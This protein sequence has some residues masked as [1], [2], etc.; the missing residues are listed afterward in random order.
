MSTSVKIITESVICELSDAGITES[1]DR[2]TSESLG[3]LT[4]TD[5]GFSLSYDEQI[6]EEGSEPTSTEIIY[7][8]NAIL[9]KRRGAVKCDFE[10]REGEGFTTLYTVTPYSFDTGIY[11]RR[12]RGAL[13]ENGGVVSILY[14]MEIGGAKKNVR[15]KLTVSPI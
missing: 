2:T 10:F 4:K 13:S 11:T 9:L 12:I 14:D 15:M 3:Q 6:G 5:T 8:S 7:S 1:S